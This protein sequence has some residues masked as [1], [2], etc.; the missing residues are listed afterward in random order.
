M[1]GKQG[2]EG[3]LVKFS[4]SRV[5]TTLPWG[6]GRAG[7]KGSA[8]P[9]ASLQKARWLCMH[10]WHMP[11]EASTGA[12]YAGTAGPGLCKSWWLR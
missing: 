4:I 6:R 7:H 3:D 2:Q 12:V 1:Q 10:T 9:A 5:W 8:V 11:G